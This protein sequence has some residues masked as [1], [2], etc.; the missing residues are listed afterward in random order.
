M[1]NPAGPFVH[2]AWWRP[3]LG[4]KEWAGAQRTLARQ[5]EA[6]GWQVTLPRAEKRGLE[7]S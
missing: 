1:V 5:A 4:L 7:A 6:G 2:L 3:P